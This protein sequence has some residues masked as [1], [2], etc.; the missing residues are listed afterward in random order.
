MITKHQAHVIKECLLIAKEATEQKLG[1]TTCSFDPSYQDD[2]NLIEDA[3]EYLVLTR[4]EN[5]NETT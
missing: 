2:L 1:N 5:E 4:K 3:M